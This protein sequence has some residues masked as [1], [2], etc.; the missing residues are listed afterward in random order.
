MYSTAL[1]LLLVAVVAGLASAAPAVAGD[2]VLYRCSD[3]QGNPVFANSRQ[4]Y[5][6][7]RVIGNYPRQAATTRVQ[8]LQP[9][10]K[11]DTAA[12]AAVPAAAGSATA[13]AAPAA[14]APARTV[15]RGA[16][17]RYEKDGVV[18]YTNVNPGR[19][20]A[21]VLF[22]YAIENCI[23]CNLRSTVDWHSVALR[24]EEF[25]A[26]IAAATSVHGVDVA[27]VRAII[28][29][30]SAYRSNAV[31]HAGA[32]GLMQLMPATAQRF[33]VTDVYDPGQNIAGGVE[34]LAWLL[35]R[36][37]GDTR[38]AAA[39]YNAGEGAVDRHGGVPPY[40][41]TQVYVER[42]GILHARYRAA[43]EGVLPATTLATGAAG[44]PP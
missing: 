34:Y 43:L 2:N 21:S 20:Q 39:G 36:F 8:A 32:Q 41:E 37:N 31:S 18:H 27:L 11:P 35:K 10:A 29:A 23:A 14:A 4:G 22:T 30:E 9:A 5:S 38:L 19:G 26:E 40:A 1:R 25:S 16:V 24:M 17:Y 33:G 13:G 7:C 42:V 15:Q 6:D 3:A 28:H 44:A 12:A